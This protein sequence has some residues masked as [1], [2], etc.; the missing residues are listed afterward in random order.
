M[1]DKHFSKDPQE[2]D[3]IPHCILRAYLAHHRFTATC[4]LCFI[5][6]SFIQETFTICL[7]LGI[8]KNEQDTFPAL[9][10]L[11]RAIHLAQLC[12]CLAASTPEQVAAGALNPGSLRKR[13]RGQE[14]EDGGGGV[15]PT[16]YLL[17]FIFLFCILFC[18]LSLPNT[19]TTEHSQVQRR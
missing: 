6:N 12:R 1:L 11:L 2:K 13:R 3:F 18:L 4:M 16:T 19:H 9:H 10:R 14:R 5:R 15:S 7:H 17:L 8:Y